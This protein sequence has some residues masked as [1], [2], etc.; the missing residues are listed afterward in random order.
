[1]NRKKK[2]AKPMPDTAEQSE[3][4]SLLRWLNRFVNG[5]LHRRAAP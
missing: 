5:F 2:H 3:E 1:M 4:S